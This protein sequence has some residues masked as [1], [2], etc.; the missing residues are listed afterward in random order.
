MTNKLHHCFFLAV[1]LGLPSFLHCQV[2]DSAGFFLN[3]KCLTHN[4]ETVICTWDTPSTTQPDV[5]YEI[6]YT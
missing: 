5:Q 2:T 1:V 3:L 4:Q 6:C